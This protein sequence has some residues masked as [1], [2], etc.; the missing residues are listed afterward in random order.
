MR[1]FDR[2]KDIVDGIG[3]IYE[4]TTLLFY[5]QKMTN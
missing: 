5:G 1:I 3:V 2:R 4:M